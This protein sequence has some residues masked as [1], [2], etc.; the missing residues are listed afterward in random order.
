VTADDSTE[1]R[2]D[3]RGTEAERDAA[4]P[5]DDELVHAA[6]DALPAQVALLDADGVIVATNR[7]W[8]TFGLD[9][10]LQ[11][12]IDM[13]GVNYLAV[14]DAS[15]DEMG[16]LAAAGI[17]AVLGGERDIYTLEYP[18]H[19]PEARR[20]FT[21]RAIR[22]PGFAGP[23]ALVMHVDITDRKEAELDVASQNEVLETVASVLS[24]DL[25]NPLNVAMARAEMAGDEAED[26]D[27]VRDHAA[28]VLSSLQ[29][30]E[31]IIG[32][33]LVLARQSDVEATE[34]V[35]VAT[36]A[37]TAW[38]HVATDDATLETPAEVTV[39]ADGSLLE[40]LFENLF[41]NAQEHAG[42]AVTVTVGH[43][44]DGFYVE[45][46]GPGVPADHR[47]EVFEAGFTTNS[48]EGGTGMG[49]AIVERIADA[50]GWT[51]SLADGDGGARFDFTDVTVSE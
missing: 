30:M 44:P 24:H 6:F 33:A 49:L 31:A 29:R 50:H 3:G 21:M 40:Q 17:R 35:D 39:E 13:V 23:H 46:D 48:A 16:P 1:R 22:L 51:V 41:R 8:E 19:S 18:C 12:D 15:D 14:C 7:A 2:A 36:S 4:G 37:R 5:D 47:D 34:P 27:A 32:D 25:R 20:W 11:G 28:A 26:G 43:L 10:D 9:N 42:D 38:S 45:D